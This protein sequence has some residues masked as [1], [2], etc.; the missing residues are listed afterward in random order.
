LPACYTAKTVWLTYKEH[1]EEQVSALSIN[2]RII[3]RESWGIAI[4]LNCNESS[5]VG[6]VLIN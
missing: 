6:S 3:I 5:Q 4:L 1:A 2:M